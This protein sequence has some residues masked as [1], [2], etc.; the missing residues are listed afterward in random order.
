[1]IRFPS[2]Q[3]LDYHSWILPF[4]LCAHEYSIEFLKGQRDEII[5]PSDLT[6]HHLNLPQ[7]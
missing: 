4:P 1:M 2:I 6:A 3:S 5:G 7:F